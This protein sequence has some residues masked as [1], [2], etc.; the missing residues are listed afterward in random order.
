MGTAKFEVEK[1][2]RSNDFRLWRLKMRAFL[3]HQ[4]LEDALKGRAGLPQTMSDQEKKILIEKAH[5]VIILSLGD[6]VLRKVSKEKTAAGVWSKLEGLYMTKSLVNW[7]Y[8]KQDLYSFKIHEDKSIDEQL[9]TFNKLIL[10]LEN[11]DVTIDDE[12]QTL[13]L[14]SSLPKSYSNFKDTLLYGRDSLMLDEVQAALN[15]KELNHRSKDKGNA[16]VEGLNVRGR[17]DKRE[18][19]QRSKSRSKS[20]FKI[21]CYH[22]HKE[23]HIRRLCPEGRSQIKKG[24]MIKLMLL[25]LMKGMSH[26]MPLLFLVLMLRK[27]GSWIQDA[28]FT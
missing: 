23:G 22:C 24:R 12:D 8:L 21:K 25:L 26:Q 18:F 4:G 15:S 5:S 6:K 3:V 2:T 16:V 19:K 20:R 17:S 7:L 13:L 14:L 10:D 1:F 28:C 11:I 9:D 27:N